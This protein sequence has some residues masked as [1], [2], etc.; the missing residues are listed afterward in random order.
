MSPIAKTTVSRYSTE[1]ARD[2]L[3]FNNLHRPCGIYMPDRTC[4]ICYV[5]ELGP[6]TRTNRNYPNL[7]PR[8]SIIDNR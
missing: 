4:P 2:E 8:V 1:T 3:Q 6:A 7:G 5:G